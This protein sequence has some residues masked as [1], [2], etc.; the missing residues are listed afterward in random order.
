MGLRLVFLSARTR[1]TPE[2][3]LGASFLTWSLLG[4]F[5]RRVFRNWMDLTP[6]WDH[7]ANVG[8]NLSVTAS[9]YF[10]VLFTYVVF[11]RDRRW[12]LGLTAV[13]G[14]LLFAAFGVVVF[15][16]GFA[17]ASNVPSRSVSAITWLVVRGV[18]L[19]WP[20]WE[21]L[22]YYSRLRRR[23]ALGLAKPE[24]ANRILLFGGISVLTF[25]YWLN[26]ILV[27]YVYARLGIPPS[28][29]TTIVYTAG[30]CI[31]FVRAILTL[32]AFFPTTT[33]LDWIRRRA[34][35]RYPPA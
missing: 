4:I 18:C 7:F 1:K 16:G 6:A 13:L 9:V 31:T 30:G 23:L 8:T 22:L 11:R 14:V 3:F 19:L 25:L 34:E 2:L 17:G 24:V 20:C 29:R 32:L 12:A 21:S 5:L 27:L 15:T 35:R 10:I 33:Y 28:M 26:L